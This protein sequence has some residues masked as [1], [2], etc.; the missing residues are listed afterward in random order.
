ML[1]LVGGTVYTSPDAE[2]VHDA[3]V[4]IDGARILSVGTL[5]HATIPPGS[6]QIDCRGRYVVAGFWNSHVHFFERKWSNAAQIPADELD[7]QLIKYHRYGFTTVFDLSST[8]ANT[9]ALRSRIESG[10][11][12]GPSIYTTGEG[13]IPPGALPEAAVLRMMGVMDVAMPEVTDA[14]GARIAVSR[15]LEQGV[16]AIKLFMSTPPSATPG[17]LPREVISQAVDQA[18]AHGKPVFTHPNSTQDVRDALRAGADVI[19]H[20]TPATQWDDACLREIQDSN[21]AL[22]PTLTIW[23][24]F[25]RHDRDS[26]QE[27]IVDSALA[28]LRAWI[29]AGASVLFGTDAGAVDIDPA[30]EYKLMAQAGMNTKHILASLTS[31]PAKRFGARERGTI[32]EGAYAD[33]VVLDAEPLR[34]VRALTRVAYTIRNGRIVYALCR[35]DER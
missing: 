10:E 29:D 24:Y 23:K 17:I 15:L 27:K 4:L 12:N 31:T 16:D 8:F 2:P 20:T 25:F 5:A 6:E 9:S 13:L 33:L 21:A 3:V 7:T 28:Q 11:V 34:D 22:T 14:F 26:V 1:A 30:P 35:G 32:T 19:G 18:H